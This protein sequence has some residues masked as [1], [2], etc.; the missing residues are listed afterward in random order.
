M[1][2]LPG[3]A[4]L[5]LYTVSAL[6]VTCDAQTLTRVTDPSNPIVTDHYESGGGA[7][8]DVDR[9]GFLDLYVAHGNLSNQNNS[10]YMNDRRGGYIKVA[11]GAIVNDGGSSI[12]STWGDYDNDGKLDVFVTN[13]NS[14]GNFLYRGNGDSTFTKVTTGSVVTDRANS[15][16]SSW[17]DVDGDGFL[18]LYVVNFQGNDY[19][20]RNNGPPLF[21][22]TRID[23]VVPVG[24]GSN[25]SI[26][27]AW[28]DMNNDRRPDLFVGNAGNQ[29]DFLYINNGNL[30]FTKIVIPDGRTTLGGSWGDYNN[31]GNLDLVTTGYLGQNDILYRNSGPPFYNLIPDTVSIVSHEGGNCVGSAWGDFNNDGNLDLFVANDGGHSHLYMNNGPPDYSFTAV[32]VGDPVTNVGNSF[33]CAWVDID[34]D[35]FLDLFVANRLNQQDFLYHNSGNSN[36]WIEIDLTGTASNRSAIG[37]KVRLYAAINGVPISQTR[38]VMAQT[39]YN[40]QV[41][42]LHFG[43]GDA[44]SVDSIKVA[45]PSGNDELFTQVPSN[46]HLAIAEKDSSVPTP[47]QPANGSQGLST[48]VAFQWTRPLYDAPFWLEVSHDST[49]SSGL[50]VNDSAVVDTTDTLAIPVG[51]G[52]LYWRVRATR[53]I[54]KSKWSSAWNFI[55]G[56]SAF[57]EGISNGWNL[58]SLPVSPR[59]PRKTSLFPT[60]QTAAF[61]YDSTY[62]ASD[63]LSTGAGYWLRFSGNQAVDLIGLPVRAETVG[64]RIGWNLI[65]SVFDSIPASSVRSNPPGIITSNFFLYRGGYRVAETLAP[66]L[67]YWVKTD[68]DGTIMLGSGGIFAAK[69]VHRDRMG[70]VDRL[71][72]LVIRDREGNTQMLY[73]GIDL[74]PEV[75]AKF[76]ELPPPAPEGSFDAR[77]QSNRMIESFTP[78]EEK[79]VPIFVSSAAYPV[80][81]QW[82]SKSSEELQFKLVVGKNER[83]LGRSGAYIISTPAREGSIFLLSVRGHGLPLLFSLSGCYPNPFNP[84]TTISYV[85]GEPVLTTLK[86]Y[87]ILGREV[88]TLVN[89][90]RAPGT[91]RAVWDA[92]NYPSGVYTYRIVAGKFTDTRKM[93]L[94][95]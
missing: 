8:I 90:V 75:T 47:I 55:L 34:G 69:H 26:P 72:S 77:F 9:D 46:Q 82:E 89:E 15:N 80:T 36:H 29:N 50:I 35:G 6:L 83:D 27:G 10:L 24:D 23:T 59:D 5:G 12:G 60:A 63:S 56:D 92:A 54:Y 40:S 43:L 1:N 76:N 81:L 58:V 61:R 42:M 57:Q 11:T 84:M 7:W 87:D 38:E 53:S 3:T 30:N 33:G 65:G 70:A 21:D 32:A 95:R 31:D 51:G 39:G 94:I 86:V 73:F 64:V 44:A 37:A 45:W 66:G 25:F 93:E 91:Y 85:V 68:S 28:A 52:R 78:T 49:F 14:F 16:S 41:L 19:L 4:L 88:A 79:R 67:G 13:R 22:F 18:D 2:L 74:D 62:R 17:V 71:H 48:P 20:Y